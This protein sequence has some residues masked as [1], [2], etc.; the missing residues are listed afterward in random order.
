MRKEIEAAIEKLREDGWGSEIND[1]IASLLLM[2]ADKIDTL[3]AGAA[4]VK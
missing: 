3:Q 4:P 2:L 1:S